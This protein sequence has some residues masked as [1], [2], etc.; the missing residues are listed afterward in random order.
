LL[1]RHGAVSGYRAP[2]RVGVDAASGQGDFTAGLPRKRMAAGV[3]LTDDADRVVIVEPV[4]KDHWRTGFV[5]CGEVYA[6]GGDRA[7]SGGARRR[8]ILTVRSTGRGV[9]V[10][11]DLVE[12]G[13]VFVTRS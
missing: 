9:G 11:P 13:N 12:I 8:R 2:V 4:Y 5:V 7:A 1:G 3:L 10:A 6:R